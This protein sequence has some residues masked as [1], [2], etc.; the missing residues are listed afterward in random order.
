MYIYLIKQATSNTLVTIGKIYSEINCIM[1]PL[2]DF[3]ANFRKLIN[4]NF[5]FEDH[6]QIIFNNRNRLLFLIVYV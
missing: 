3:G 4:S 5:K 1:C 6:S 2:K